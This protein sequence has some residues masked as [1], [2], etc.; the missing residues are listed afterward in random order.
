MVTAV[1]NYHCIAGLY[2]G[3]NLREGGDKREF[4]E[5]MGGGGIVEACPPEFF[6]I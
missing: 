1:Y 6:C 3:N 4:C 2:L 5:S